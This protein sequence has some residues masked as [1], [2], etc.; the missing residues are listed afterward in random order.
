MKRQRCLVLIWVLAVSCVWGTPV[1]AASSSPR[2][3][4]PQETQD[5]IDGWARDN[6]DLT[7]D[8]VF[9]DRCAALKDV[10]WIACVRIVPGYANEIEYTLS[11]EKSY[12]GTILAHITRPKGQ[13]VYSQLCRRKKERPHASVGALA[14]LIKLESQAGDQRRFPGLVSLADEFEKIRFSPVPP[15]EL[16]M[17]ATRY[18]FCIRSFSGDKM[19]ILLRGPGP[20]APGQPLI[21]IQWAESVREL[22]ASAFK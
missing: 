21:L 13:S 15:D 1:P 6:Y 12:G 11:V 2:A 9:R 22:L 3:S 14:R 19:E 4:A 16:M 18:R 10:R 8:L 20:T 17:D 5:T 7:L